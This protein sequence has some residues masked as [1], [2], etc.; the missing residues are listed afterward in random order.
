MPEVPR[1]RAMDASVTDTCTALQH[2][3]TMQRIRGDLDED[4]KGAS[5]GEDGDTMAFAMLTQS[6]SDQN[7]F[8]R[9]KFLHIYQGGLV[10]MLLHGAMTAL[11]YGELDLTEQWRYVCEWMFVSACVFVYIGCDCSACML[12]L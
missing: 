4:G 12:T 5:C 10:N 11:T 1:L 9:L 2:H 6:V 8:F 3:A 7:D